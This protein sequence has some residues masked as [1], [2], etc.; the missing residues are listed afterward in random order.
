MQAIITK[1]LSATNCKGARIKATCERGSVT[2]SY[3]YELSGDACHIEAANALVARFIAD[4]DK[5][6]RYSKKS[7]NP[8]A[9]TRVCGCLPSG[10]YAHVYLETN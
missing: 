2:I 8:W 4:D 1:Y 9:S 5:A 6:G 10:E 7:R 3:P